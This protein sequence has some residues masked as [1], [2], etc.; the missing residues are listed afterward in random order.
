[1]CV[2]GE[3]QALLARKHPPPSPLIGASRAA[4]RG[5]GGGS[6]LDKRPSSRASSSPAP[7]RQARGQAGRKQGAATRGPSSSPRAFIRGRSA[8]SSSSFGEKAPQGQRPSRDDKHSS[9]RALKPSSASRTLNILKKE[10]LPHFVRR[11][12]DPKRDKHTP[13]AHTGSL[14]G[15]PRRT[16]DTPRA[17]PSEPHT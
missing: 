8:S 6:I 16:Q 4:H 15:P 11:N 3:R 10:L 17:T 9:L 7:R 5:G 13:A 1:L 12:F 14:L 2:G